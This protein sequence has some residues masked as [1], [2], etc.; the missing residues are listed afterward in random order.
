[1]RAAAQYLPYSQTGAF[2]PLVIDYLERGLLRECC[3]YEPDLNSVKA[4]I[5]ARSAFP[6]D[7]KLLVSVMKDYYVNHQPYEKVRSNLDLLLSENTFTVC[8]AHQPHLFTGPVY[9]IYKIIHAIKLAAELNQKF[10]D[11]RFVPV[12][13]MGSEDADL[14]ELGTVKSNGRVF[15]WKTTQK[16][17]IGRMRVDGALRSMLE[18]FMA[19][20]PDAPGADA[21]ISS[22]KKYFAEGH[23]VEQASFALVNELFGKYGLLIFLPDRK[24]FKRAFLPVIKEELEHAIAPKSLKDPMKELSRRYKI[25]A[26]VKDTNLFYLTDTE[27]DRI[28]RADDGFILNKSGRRFSMQEM[29]QLAE[30]H[31]ECFSPNVILRPVFQEILLPNVAFIGGGAEV[32]YWLEL[33]E[34]FRM[35]RVPYPIVLLRNSFLMLHP[36]QYPL[37]E[38]LGLTPL[39]LFKDPVLLE[40]EWMASKDPDAQNLEKALSVI[41]DIYP[42]VL[43]SAREV[44]LGMDNHMAALRKAAVNRLKYKEKRRLKNLKRNFRQSLADINNLSVTA[45]P[46]GVLQE[47]VDNYLPWLAQ[48]GND[49]TDLLFEN[50]SGF[51]KEFC[52][53][54]LG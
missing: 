42:G 39:Q 54:S 1:M 16:G 15:K 26:V 7:R 21:V 49:L 50:A 31:P 48:Y 13:F 34:L 53:L 6:T 10:P 22:L 8:A 37:M 46:G 35:L 11:S 24:E 47:R 52:I 51:G 33:R 38:S 9:F 18:E 12:Y 41:E 27:R 25:P 2:A 14:E 4:A 45:M 36:G 5:A 44:T 20:F 19:C 30:S 32:S 29:L 23:T 43:Q 40:K 17:S 3:E 28:D